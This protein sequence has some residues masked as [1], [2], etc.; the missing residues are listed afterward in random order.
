MRSCKNCGG[1]IEP[2]DGGAIW[3]HADTAARFCDGDDERA[4]SW[5]EAVDCAEPEGIS[6]DEAYELYD[7]WLVEISYDSGFIGWNGE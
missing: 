1:A 3:Y 4:R 7:E 2:D 6:E 5:A